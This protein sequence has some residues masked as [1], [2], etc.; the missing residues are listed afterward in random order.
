MREVDIL[1]E[2]IGILA[3]DVNS[4][5]LALRAGQGAKSVHDIAGNPAPQVFVLACSGVEWCLR[6]LW[7]MVLWAG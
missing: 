4:A 2:V 5:L 3:E 1:V 7:S 6:A